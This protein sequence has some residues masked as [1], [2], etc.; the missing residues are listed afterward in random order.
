MKVSII[1]PTYNR[2]DSLIETINS[3]EQ[4]D[5]PRKKFEIIIVDDC[6]TDDTKKKIKKIS[7]AYGNI[8]YLKTEKNSGPA[9][10]RNLGIKHSKGEYIF[11]T[12]DDC[13][14]PKNWIK[15]Y[16][17]IFKNNPSVGG[18]GGMLMPKS[19]NFFSKIEKIKDKLKL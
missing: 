5:Y 15:S 8:K 13:I 16:L 11:F 19:H 17:K 2:I 18:I 12:D 9:A 10:A 7:K 1:V 14:V 6:S 3:I 4:N